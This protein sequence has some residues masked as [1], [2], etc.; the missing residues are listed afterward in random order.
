[1][2]G[3]STVRFLALIAI[4]AVMVTAAHAADKEAG[5]V[6]KR[7]RKP[8]VKDQDRE[9]WAFKKPSAAPVPQVRASD[10]LRT[11]VDAF[12]L[13]KLEAK[14][15]TYSPDASKATLLRRAYLD[16]IGLPPSPDEVRNFQADTRPDAYER[17]VDRLLDSPH[18]GERWGRHWL[19]VAGYTD[20]PHC[21]TQGSFL[22]VDDWRYRDYVVRAFNQDKPYDRF[23]AEQL[24]GDELVDWRSAK[25]F[26]PEMLDALIATGYLR[27]TP[28]WTHGDQFQS[29]YRIDTMAR[30]VENVSTGLLG[31]TM[32]CVRC[33][34]HKFD[35]IPH[36]DYYRL[37]AVFATA[38]NPESWLRP[39]ERYLPDIS[40]AEKEPIDRHNAQIEAQRTELTKQLAALREPH[41][42][43]L[44]AAKLAKLP[45]AIR[46]DVEAALATL[47][48]KRTEVQRY[49]AEKFEAVLA[50]PDAE[51]M[52]TFSEAERALATK[53]G[54]E[55]G[56]LL[57]KK[58][59]FGRLQ[60]LWDVGKPPVVRQLIRGDVRTPG[61][62]VEPGYI[63]VLCP[64]GKSNLVPARDV[65]EESSGRRIAFARWLTSRENPLTARVIV[66]RV[67]QHHFG[68]GIVAT[69]ENFGRSGSP[70]T[71]P[72]LLDWL[73][74]DFMEHGWSVKHL[75]RLLMTS[76]AYRQSAHRP[77]DGEANKSAR[78][79]SDNDL[80]WHM[81][82]RRLEAEA[83][84]DVVLAVSSKLDRTMAGPPIPVQSNP[85][86]LVVVTEKGPTPTSKWR[87]SLYVRSLRGS[88]PTGVG[89][90]LSMFEIFDF[91]E[92]VI[93]C[94][95]RSNSTTPLQS[96]ALI[97]S[98]FMLKQA[99]RFAERVRGTTTDKNRQI[100]TAFVL[101]FGRMPAAA[102]TQFCLEYLQTQQK[103]YEQSKSPAEQAAQRALAGLCSVLLA[104]NEFLYIP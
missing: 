77:A 71:H 98:G 66:N 27:T 41:R 51:V 92:V 64:P 33:H 42:K 19:D 23:L 57:A 34:R 31:L 37:M 103:L 15:L 4:V 70:P 90:R 43:K 67:W 79:D 104:S 81:N 3:N 38:Y 62:I 72:E 54:N 47:P 5:K 87:R 24:A 50:C 89:F 60:A 74:V 45:Q 21:D 69:P 44:F 32:G 11:P 2:N 8:V 63:T 16:L 73:A 49:L 9:Y 95:R 97:N 86:G 22:P 1:M 78:V 101:A 39:H 76:T 85:D 7:A 100:D 91:P 55:L 12:L 56:G 25:K 80:L 17:L 30:V 36:E 88:H 10:R 28:D 35:P 29:A 13:A 82:L 94:T 58:K 40:P 75:H 53:L 99:R 68:K 102:E 59:T 48:A 96:L 93:N 84:R 61:K 14:G 65:A 6:E 26:T 52:K 46:A 20:S 83:V 18:Y